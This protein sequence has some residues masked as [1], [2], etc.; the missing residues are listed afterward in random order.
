MAAWERRGS[1]G[2]LRSV[3]IFILGRRLALTPCGKDVAAGEGAGV[4]WGPWGRKEHPHRGSKA[5]APPVTL[6][7]VP[8]ASLRESFL[9][10]LAGTCGTPGA[11]DTPRLRAEGSAGRDRSRAGTT[12]KLFNTHP[13]A[14]TTRGVFLGLGTHMT[15]THGNT[16]D[17]HAMA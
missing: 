2:P 8:R 7:Q 5:V 12:L 1:S 13:P 16:G 14:P 3:H 11:G 17:S 10:K 15:N 6:P 4:A 9:E